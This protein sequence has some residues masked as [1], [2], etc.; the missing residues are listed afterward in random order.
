MQAAEGPSCFIASKVKVQ[1]AV[2]VAFFSLVLGVVHHLNHQRFGFYL[3][4]F[5]SLL[6]IIGVVLRIGNTCAQGRLRQP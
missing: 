2:V 5:L 3:V 6:L 4:A 1:N